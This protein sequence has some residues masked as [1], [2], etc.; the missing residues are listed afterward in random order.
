MA[1]LPLER[2]RTAERAALVETIRAKGAASE[3]S[4]VARFAAHRRLQSD[5]WNI[6]RGR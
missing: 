1:L 4:Y 6:A 3:R 5:L 2:W